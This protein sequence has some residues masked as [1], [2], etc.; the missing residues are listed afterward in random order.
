MIK[1]YNYGQVPAS[2]IFA[3]ENPTANVADI[4]SDIIDN[5]RRRGDEALLEYARRFDRAELSSL[6]VTP[7]E[8]EEAS[9]AIDKEIAE[10]ARAESVISEMPE[11]EEDGEESPEEE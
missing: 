4:V 11:D 8:I 1:I 10:S 6:E 3:R 7:E 2:E 5:V 9:E